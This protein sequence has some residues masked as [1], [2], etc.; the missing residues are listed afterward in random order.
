MKGISHVKEH[1]R[2]VVNRADHGVSGGFGAS[3]DEGA[4][5]SESELEIGL[6]RLETRVVN[7]P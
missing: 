4:S 3:E 5:R 2:H 1:Q 7:P 6:E